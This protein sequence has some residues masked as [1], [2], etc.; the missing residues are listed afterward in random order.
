MKTVAFLTFR[1]PRKR[2]S[3]IVLYLYGESYTC[4]QEQSSVTYIYGRQDRTLP[5]CV[6]RCEQDGQLATSATGVYTDVNDRGRRYG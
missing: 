1:L 5:L 2:N 4:S 6:Q 3:F